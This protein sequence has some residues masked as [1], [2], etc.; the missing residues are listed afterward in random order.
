MFQLFN[1]NVNAIEK[2]DCNDHTIIFSA[3][4]EFYRPL[5]S[6]G[7][8]IKYVEAGNEKYTIDGEQFNLNSGQYLLSNLFTEGKVEIESKKNVT[9]IC[10]NIMPEILSEVVGSMLKPDTAEADIGLD[11]FFTTTNFLNREYTAT[12]TILG[13]ELNKLSISANK[14][15]LSPADF[16]SEFFYT[17]AEK[18]VIDCIPL[19]KQLNAIGTQKSITKKYLLKKINTGKE[20]IDHHFL[21]PISVEHIAQQSTISEYHFYRLFKLVYGMSPYQMILAKRLEFAKNYLLFSNLPVSVVAIEAGFSDINS[22]SKSF[23]K[24][25]GFTPSLAQINSRILPT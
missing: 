15:N 9:G 10:I 23:K 1:D 18:I 16:G 8:A 13:G 25:Y 4:N 20:Y 19:C 7:F 14:N 12:K 24:Y 3:L 11:T 2:I 22:F 6:K 17:L 5:Q 21:S